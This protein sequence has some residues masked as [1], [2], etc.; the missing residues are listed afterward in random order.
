MSWL[1]RPGKTKEQEGKVSFPGD[2]IFVVSRSHKKVYVSMLL[3]LAEMRYCNIGSLPGYEDRRIRDRSDSN[4]SKDIRKL[5]CKTMLQLREGQFYFR[6]IKKNLL[7][8]LLRLKRKVL[9]KEIFSLFSFFFFFLGT[10][11]LISKSVFKFLMNF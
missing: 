3:L 9:I 8:L 10:I 7:K 5:C 6:K 1:P 11:Y 2:F 4:V